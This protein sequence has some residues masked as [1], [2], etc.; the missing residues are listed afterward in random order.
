M[1][2]HNDEETMA[3]AESLLQS[4]SDQSIWNLYGQYN[5]N[6]KIRWKDSIK[7]IVGDL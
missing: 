3:R 1:N 7:K 5:D 4:L 6:Q 2:G